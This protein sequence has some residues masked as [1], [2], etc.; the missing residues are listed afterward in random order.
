M[1]MTNLAEQIVNRMQTDRVLERHKEVIFVAH[2][3]G[4]LLVEQ[5][6]LDLPLEAP[7]SKV[8]AIFFY[9]TPHEGSHL[10][11]LYKFFSSDPLVKELQAGDANLILRDVDQRWAL[12]DLKIKQFCAFEKRTENGAR[13]VDEYSATRGNCKPLGIDT[14]HRGLVK[15]CSVRDDS[16][17]FLQNGLRSIAEEDASAKPNNPAGPVAQPPP[18]YA[19]PNQ[20]YGPGPIAP[21]MGVYYNLT[22]LHQQFLQLQADWVSQTNMIQRQF[23]APYRMRGGVG[24]PATM[25][26]NLQDSLAG[27]DR[28]AYE[29]YA[30]NRAQLLRVRDIAIA[31]MQPTP[32]ELSKDKE[33]FLNAEHAAM[34]PIPMADIRTD[35]PDTYRFQPIAD[36]VLNLRNRLGQFHC[37]MP[38]H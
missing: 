31:C 35:H 17:T 6:L 25:P 9:G 10:A 12:A 7:S 32:N 15:P 30:N 13:V 38:N 11:N 18:T 8:R 27:T 16:F 4:G 33:E 2:S 28:Q 26:D 23:Y 29:N 19:D 21:G 22:N 36:Y 24:M 3:L 34:K 14:D 5:I 37:D 1:T 20:P